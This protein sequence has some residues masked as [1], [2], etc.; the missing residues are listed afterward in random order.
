MSSK[1]KKHEASEELGKE[2]FQKKCYTD[3]NLV[4]CV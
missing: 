1:T 2:Y 4:N 3:D